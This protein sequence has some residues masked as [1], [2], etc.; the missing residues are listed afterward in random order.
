MNAL[1]QIPIATAQLPKV[2]E[3]AQVALANCASVDECKDWADKAAALASY[4]KQ[5]DDETLMKQSVRIRDRAIRRMGELLKQFD[6]QGKRTDKLADGA[7]SKFSQKEIAREAGISERQ[8]VTAVRVANVPREEF[9]AL[10]ESDRPPSITELAKR[11]ITP[12]PL[13]DLKGRDPQAF[14]RCLHFVAAVREYA[15]EI[16][17]VNLDATIDALTPKEAGEVRAL[18]G[19][20]DAI[21]DAIITRI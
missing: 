2:Y 7:D 1:A 11:G 15:A 8:Q 12:R 9:E 18:I 17:R 5:A 13:V 20:I 4:A 3:A 6:G 16:A 10:V 21:H 14:N 19:R